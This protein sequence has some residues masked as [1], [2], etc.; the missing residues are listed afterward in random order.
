[1][2]ARKAVS[3]SKS[4][5]ISGIRSD[6]PTPVSDV[7]LLIISGSCVIREGL[8][9]LLNGHGQAMMER[10]QT[11]EP[12]PEL[13]PR[14][15]S[16]QIVLLDGTSP[17]GAMLEWIVAC[18]STNPLTQFM[19]IE[20]LDNFDAVL[21]YTRA[22]VRAYALRGASISEIMMGIQ[23]LCHGEGYCSPQLTGRM[24]E[25]LSRSEQYLTPPAGLT[26]REFE[27]L[28]Y[29]AAEY[30]NQQIAERL[31]I[32]VR[33]VKHHVHSILQKLGVRHRWDAAR[34]FQSEGWLQQK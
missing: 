12:F 28:H 20:L 16:G 25:H 21:A 2:G 13:S 17:A 26:A 3:M 27:V 18:R 32:D 10:C 30:S 15:S 6:C 14:L 5:I 22:G 11:Y 29:L 8:V 31:V 7:D 9:A 24:F 23:A 19:V 4:S 33:T 34:V 1:M